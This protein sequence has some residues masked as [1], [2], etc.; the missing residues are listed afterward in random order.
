VLN[1]DRALLCSTIR[2]IPSPSTQTTVTGKAKLFSAEISRSCEIVPQ[3]SLLTAAHNL[4]ILQASPLDH[5]TSC[6][7]PHQWHQP[8]MIVPSA[9]YGAD[10]HH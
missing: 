1:I 5:P 3:H 10:I 6:S 7:P 8:S 2:L 4:G 9:S